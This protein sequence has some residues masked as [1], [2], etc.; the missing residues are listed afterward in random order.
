MDSRVKL[1]LLGVSVL[2]FA[3]QARAAEQGAGDQVQEIVITGSRVIK[4]GDA[5]PTP[6]TVLSTDALLQT[7][8]T[9]I[10][11]G[12]NKLPQFA[13]QPSTR[14]IGN[15]LTNATGNYLNLRKF[16]ANRNLVLLDG[17]R[18][19]PSAA[20]GAVDTN[21]M[22]QG[23]VQR[24]D[25]VTGGGSAVYG[26][27]AVTGVIN[28]VLDKKFNGFKAV[29]QA[30]T[31]T[32][33]DDNSWRA[34]FTAG[35][36]VLDG[37]GHVEGNFDYYNSNGIIGLDSRPAG[38]NDWVTGG[39]GSAA[40][41]FRLVA[42]GRVLSANRGGILTGTLPAAL[43]NITFKSDG[44]PTA[45]IHGTSGGVSGVES[46]GDGGLFKDGTIAA[47]LR[48]KQAFVRFDYDLST[49]LHA[50]VQGAY[51]DS[52]TQYPYTTRI[53]LNQ[54]V[55]SGTA[56]IPASIQQIMTA[57]NMTSLG[58]GRTSYLGGPYSPVSVRSLSTNTF[59]EAGLN[60]R[61]FADWSWRAN[62]T[63]SRSTQRVT[64]LNNVSIRKLAAALDAVVDP[65]SG[66]VVCQVSLTAAASRF[67]G[68][69]PFNPFGPTAPSAAAYN[70]VNQDTR[71]TLINGMHDVSFSTAGSL[72]S[73]WA[74]PVTAAFNGEYRQL[75]LANN[76]AQPNGPP[77]CAGLR[78]SPNCTATTPPF[79]GSVTGSMSASQ[80]VAEG[81]GELLI[82]LARDMPFMKSVE[83]NLAGR[84][85]RYSTSGDAK[86]W[87][88]GGVWAVDTQFKI[89]GT[90]SQ[91]IRAP[92]LTDLF[93][94]SSV[95]QTGFND[96][97]T[98]VVKI[99]FSYT[100]GNPKLVP[101]V[102]QTKTVGFVYQPDWLPRFSLAVDYY[103]IDMSNAI[104]QVT[105]TSA[106]IQTQCE[107]SNG[108][109]PYCALMQRP[110]AFSDRSAANAPTQI[111]ALGLNT[112]RQWTNGVDIE[113]N[114]RFSLRD[115]HIG[116]PGNL[117]L[118]ALFDYQPTLN[119]KTTPVSAPTNAA[120]ILGLSKW[121]GNLQA[122]YTVGGLSVNVTESWQS[123]Q[124]PSDPTVSVDLRQPVPDYFYTDLALSYQTMIAG[125][126][127][128]PFLTIDNLFNKQPPVTG[129]S[130]STP[131]IFYPTPQGYDVIGRYFTVG[132]RTRF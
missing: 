42:N 73:L 91:D 13:A 56:Y 90:V 121:R 57:N 66:Q 64:N 87:K 70:Y 75:S 33:G 37:R 129:G 47:P 18:V 24:V 2:A 41:P 52:Y 92:T 16:G 132:F 97:H 43:Q 116:A 23:L 67:P 61:L 39:N 12:L 127:I 63:Y 103:D 126:Q 62:Y 110:F 7:T 50:Y 31:S 14:N 59:L 58:F 22:P 29:A 79:V 84:F 20:S 82:P 71:Y 3:S 108:T 76:A 44:A 95:S 38:V 96:L 118:R 54:S 11:D 85:T 86:T 45:L 107:S 10:S 89:R 25:V 68:C 124:L 15:A 109:S 114:Y 49:D 98:G 93:L 48:T 40:N 130:A 32:Y 19:A 4:N 78:P 105:P 77:D 35:A 83:L 53:L 30:G 28:Y 113:A 115:A 8:P 123:R 27:D 21:T 74:G 99:L 1:L 94:P 36:P 34:G 17:S 111:F 125:H 119:T 72:F 26:S 122:V 51:N 101:E 5:A 81:G 69:Q 6:V 131:G 9:N 65:A 106:T 80:T 100:Q 55:L 60:G 102:A 112:A 104:T 120:G 46:G 88:I 128:S 117:A